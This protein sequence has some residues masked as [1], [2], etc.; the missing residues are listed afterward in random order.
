VLNHKA[1]ILKGFIPTDEGRFARVIFNQGVAGSALDLMNNK[2]VSE[3]V[4]HQDFQELQLESIPVFVSLYISVHS[5]QNLI[6][7]PLVI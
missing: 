3:G 7:S 5:H 6:L 2:A 1:P 4:S